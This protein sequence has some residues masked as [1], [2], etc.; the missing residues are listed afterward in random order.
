MMWIIGT[1][2]NDLKVEFCFR[3]VIPIIIVIMRYYW[4]VLKDVM[5]DLEELVNACWLYSVESVPKM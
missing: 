5:K 2:Y 3:N 4:R 1:I